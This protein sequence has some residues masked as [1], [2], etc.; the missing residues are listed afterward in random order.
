VTQQRPPQ[1]LGDE[2]VREGTHRGRPL[3][4][5]GPPSAL[6]VDTEATGDDALVV[7]DGGHASTFFRGFTATELD[8][9]PTGWGLVF[10]REVWGPRDGWISFT[11]DQT[12]L[13][14][15]DDPEDVIAELRILAE[16]L[17]QLEAFE[18]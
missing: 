4:V 2:V 9:S 15:I 16:Q 14:G 18:R 7:G 1:V 13:G 10:D 3:V 11:T 17:T 12:F 6:D 8:G 5:A